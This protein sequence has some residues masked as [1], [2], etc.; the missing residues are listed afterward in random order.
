MENKKRKADKDKVQD[1]R[2]QLM[3]MRLETRLLMNSIYEDVLGGSVKSVAQELGDALFNAII[4]GTSAMDALKT[5]VDEI[6]KGI[7]KAMLVQKLIEKPLGK[8][9]DKYTSTWFEGDTFLGEDK[10]LDSL[11]A[12]REELTSLGEGVIPIMQSVSD[13]LGLIDGKGADGGLGKQVS[14]IQESTANLLGSYIN[15]IRADVSIN[16]DIMNNMYKEMIGVNN[17]LSNAISYLSDIKIA[18]QRSAT[19]V[20]SILEKLE[21]LTRAGGATKLNVKAY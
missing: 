21:D 6:I 10:V 8:I 7:T 20:M 2:N 17:S 12:F 15:G 19:S 5:S 4:D 18:T 1:L 14:T 3:D 16:K 9:I 13:A 11:G